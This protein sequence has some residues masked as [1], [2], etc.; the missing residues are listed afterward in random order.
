MPQT[1]RIFLRL[2]MV[3]TLARRTEAGRGLPV[4][5]QNFGGSGAARAVPLLLCPVTDILQPEPKL[6]PWR[7][8][9]VILTLS[10]ERRGRTC[11][12]VV[13]KRTKIV[14]QITAGQYRLTQTVRG[15]HSRI[16]GRIIQRPLRALIQY[17]K[18]PPSP[19]RPSRR[20]VTRGSRCRA[21][22]EVA[23]SMRSRFPR[24]V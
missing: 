12:A 1:V 3:R 2:F 15:G 9:P 5:S 6:S 17:T 14:T 4:E 16:Q 18:Q 19:G 23:N 11:P 24:L 13:G 20:T 22:I 8:F 7:V 21:S 10:G